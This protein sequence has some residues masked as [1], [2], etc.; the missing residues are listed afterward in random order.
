V[1]PL[2]RFGTSTWTYEGW[3]GQVYKQHAA[4]E[5]TFTAPFM[6]MRLLTP[7][8]T[9]YHDAVIAYR[10]Y[11]KIVGVLPEMREQIVTRV[12][13]A[14]RRKVRAYVLV[15]NRTEGNAPLTVQALTDLLNQ[16]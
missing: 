13:D 11:D 12:K 4:M 6:V 14:V 8:N 7:R 1:P 10:P 15:N 9:K 5:K 2:I 3:Q 16:P